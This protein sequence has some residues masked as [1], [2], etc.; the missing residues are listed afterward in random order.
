MICPAHA[1]LLSGFLVFFITVYFFGSMQ[2][3]NLSSFCVHV[4]IVYRIVSWY[5]LHIS[6][7]LSVCVH[8]WRCQTLTVLRA[9][10]LSHWSQ[11]VRHVLTRSMLS[12]R[13]TSFTLVSITHAYTCVESSETSSTGNMNNVNSA[14]YSNV[15]F[16]IGSICLSVPAFNSTQRQTALLR[17][18][19][20][21]SAVVG[22]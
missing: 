21:V 11:K 8:V 10:H 6:E 17:Q 5:D 12:T 22:I 1:G 7:L 18:I 3:I 2:Q 20:L 16:K 9:V 4:N 13:N 19:Y 15:C 14:S